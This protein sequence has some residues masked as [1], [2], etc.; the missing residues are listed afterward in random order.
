MVEVE[1]AITSGAPGLH[2]FGL[3]E[4]SLGEARDRV[5]AAVF[6]SRLPWPQRHVSVSLCPASLPKRGSGYDVAIAAAVLGAQDTFPRDACAGVVF[7]AELGLDGR[8]RPLTGVLPAVLAA[9]DAGYSTVVVAAANKA[10]A[11]AVPGMTVVAAAN[12]REVVGWLNGEPAPQATSPS[13]EHARATPRPRTWPDLADLTDDPAARQALAASAAGGHHLQF[14][15][16]HDVHQMGQALLP[17]L[18]DLTLRAALEVAAIYS[19]AGLIAPRTPVS[20]QPPYRCPG[21]N[22]SRAL[23]CGNV[24]RTSRPGEMALAHHGVLHLADAP[25][26][27]AGALDALRGP[28][29]DG[30]VVVE[31]AGVLTQYP[32]RFVLLVTMAPCPCRAASDTECRCELAAVHRYQA[33]LGRPILD[34]LDI[35]VA[36]STPRPVDVLGP[37]KGG[38]TSAAAREQVAVARDRATGRL[39]GTP[40][41]SNAEIPALEL[42]RRFPLGDAAVPLETAMRN[43]VLSPHG[44]RRTALLT[45][46][47]ADLAGHDVPTTADVA[48]AI[49]LHQPVA[50]PTFPEGRDA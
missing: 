7:I 5:R 27:A 42:R 32:A 1:A 47:M 14:I 36:L 8:L 35:K 6:N 11:A 13:G 44:A 3:P 20:N 10:E 21:P 17:L 12:L 18:P 19:V 43:G 22:S 38:I 24:G 37:P 40:W 15:G 34:R 31:G 39:T 45:W 2:L 16:R 33:G 48:A 25:D 46:T 4:A 28:L 49:G 30:A 50:A 41:S 26:F 29:D 23:L 9:A